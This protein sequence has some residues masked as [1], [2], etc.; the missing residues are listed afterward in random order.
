MGRRR[1]QLA[2]LNSSFRLSAKP[3][4][5]ME[6]ERVI[7]ETMVRNVVNTRS[8]RVLAG[9]TNHLSGLVPV[10]RQENSNAPNDT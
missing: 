2:A 10:L 1:L 3:Q 6:F 7:V 5:L 8:L 9:K 4:F